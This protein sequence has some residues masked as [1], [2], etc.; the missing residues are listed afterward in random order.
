MTEAHLL[1]LAVLGSRGREWRNRFT[2]QT[3]NLHGIAARND[4]K[5]L[6][7]T[8]RT[9][10]GLVFAQ[11]RR[12]AACQTLDAAGFLQV[13][14]LSCAAIT[15]PKL[16]GI[17]SAGSNYSGGRKRWLSARLFLFR[18]PMLTE[19]CPAA[20][21]AARDIAKMINATM[22]NMGSDTSS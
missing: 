13:T 8:L 19:T 9:R 17:P 4:H 11:L 21:N 12:S 20:P 15:T 5:G 10:E 22:A 18:R 2:P 7:A 3:L 14:E 6:R 1:G 16:H